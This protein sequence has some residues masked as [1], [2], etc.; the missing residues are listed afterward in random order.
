VF[1]LFT[2]RARKV[3]VLAQEEAGLLNHNILGTAHILLGLICEGDGVAAHTLESLGVSLETVRLRVDELVPPTGSP[4]S[5]PPFTSRAKRVLA[6]AQDESRRLRHDYVGTEHILLGLVHEGES[7]SAEP[8]GT[9]GRDIVGVRGRR[10][11]L[12][13]RR[14]EEDDGDGPTEPSVALQILAELGVRQQIRR[15]VSDLL[16][17][18]PVENTP[19]ATVPAEPGH[20]PRL[21][22]CGECGVQLF[23]NARYATIEVEPGDTDR[24]QETISVVVVYCGMCG[25]THGVTGRQT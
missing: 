5:S 4:T 22:H 19:P 15:R 17:G 13:R 23:E 6:L 8:G 7:D 21:P 18:M 3:L 14:A 16:E 24:G 20:A 1:E 11:R 2:D 25:S 12:V 10:N 9:F